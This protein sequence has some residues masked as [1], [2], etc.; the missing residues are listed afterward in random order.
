MTIVVFLF[1]YIQFHEYYNNMRS[2]EKEG[3]LCYQASYYI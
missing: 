2:G 3:K 1:V